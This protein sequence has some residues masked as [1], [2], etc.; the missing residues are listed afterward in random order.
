MMAVIQNIAALSPTIKRIT[1]QA[2]DG[3]QLPNG[4]AGA[5]IILAIPG[6]N[7]VWKNAY[8]LVS[9]PDDREKYEIIV[10]RVQKSR[11][12]SAWLHDHAATGQSIEISRP[13]NLFPI[14]LAAPRH[15]LIA[16]GIGITPF[17][18]YLPVLNAAAAKFEL[19]HC[20]KQEDAAAFDALLPAARENIT[21]HTS[22]N[23]LDIA[24]RLAAQKLNT[25][26]YVCGPAE[27]MDVVIATAKNLGWPDSKLHQESFGGATGGAPFTVNLARS[28]L[29]LNVAADESLL[30]ALEAAGLNPPC[31]CR[32]GACGMCELPVLDGVPDHHDHFL[33][34][35]KKS[36]GAVIMTCVSRAKTPNLVL[37]F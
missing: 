1:L 16:A 36:G 32:G 34:E 9:P 24:K 18:A 25:H 11:G 5:H 31:L 30:E 28:G 29:S 26:L 20:C 19:H 12:G 14:S 15:L 37:D 8:S 35:A 23:S 22:R 6:P 3:A 2:A 7:R 27:F 33:S 4:A 17:L 21:L 10:R 13:A